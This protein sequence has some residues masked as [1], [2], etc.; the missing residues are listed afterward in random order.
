M[1]TYIIFLVIMIISM[2][3]ANID[4]N[5]DKISFDKFTKQQLRELSVT[6]KSLEAFKKIYKRIIAIAVNGGTHEINN[7]RP[8]CFAC[9]HSMGTE[10]MIEF[11]V[12]YGLYIG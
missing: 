6:I 9:N 12:K 8:I 7:L 11:V 3:V 10:N 2:T 1:N 5:D 4:D